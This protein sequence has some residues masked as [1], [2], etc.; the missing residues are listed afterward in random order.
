ME[1]A[2]LKKPPHLDSAVEGLGF[3]VWVG[4]GFRV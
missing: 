2:P 1:L 3:R 4:L